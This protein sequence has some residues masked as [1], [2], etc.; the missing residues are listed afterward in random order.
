MVILTGKNNPQPKVIA[1][2]YN[3]LMENV[4]KFSTAA[5]TNK[6]IIRHSQ[7]PVVAVADATADSQ[8]QPAP[9]HNAGHSQNKNPVKNAAET[10]PPPTA[11]DLQ[12]QPDAD[13]GMKSPPEDVITINMD[14]IIDG[15]IA[16]WFEESMKEMKALVEKTIQ[17]EM[18]KFVQ[19]AGVSA[20]NERLIPLIGPVL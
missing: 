13:T 1:T 3:K 2:D 17:E 20:A 14:N 7:P 10:K 19:G 11:K 8:S 18:A 16:F 4:T 15:R 6:P 5:D 12:Q 9:T